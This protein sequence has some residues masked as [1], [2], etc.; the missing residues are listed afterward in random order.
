ML[1]IHSRKQLY[2][3]TEE[4]GQNINNVNTKIKYNCESIMHSTSEILRKRKAMV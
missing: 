2:K 3:A 4:I 1:H